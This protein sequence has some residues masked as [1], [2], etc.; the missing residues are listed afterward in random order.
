MRRTWARSFVVHADLAACHGGEQLR[1]GERQRL[2]GY[3]RPPAYQDQMAADVERRGFTRQAQGVLER[4]A[5]GHQ[6]GGGENAKAMRFHDA[7]VHVRR[8]A[9]IVRR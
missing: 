1:H 4:R 2:A 9:E 3:K 6:G 5:V 7:L 8:K